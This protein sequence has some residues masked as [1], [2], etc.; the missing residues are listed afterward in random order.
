MSRDES[1]IHGGWRYDEFTLS[2]EGLVIH[3]IEWG[4]GPVWTIKAT[5]LLHEYMPKTEEA[6]RDRDAPCGAPLPYHRTYGSRIR[7]FGW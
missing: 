7:R 4:D 1:G 6:D 2:D 5:D 3:T